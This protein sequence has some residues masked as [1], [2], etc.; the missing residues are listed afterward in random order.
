MK[1]PHRPDF[2]CRSREV[3]A[4]MCV[5]VCIQIQMID[6]QKSGEWNDGGTEGAGTI[7]EWRDD[8]FFRVE[9]IDDVVQP[10]RQ[11]RDVI[12]KN[13]TYLRVFL[14]GFISRIAV[15]IDV[16]FRQGM[17][18]HLVVGIAFAG[19][20]VAASAWNAVLP[21]DHMSDFP[22]ISG[23]PGNISLLS[24]LPRPIPLDNVTQ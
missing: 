17:Y 2:P 10:D 15:E 24:R 3:S 21:D 9:Y 1:Y 18:Q 22:R 13:L 14:Q 7:A 19:S 4:L 16:V 23:E 12:I 5:V 8:E 6:I 20:A 11:K